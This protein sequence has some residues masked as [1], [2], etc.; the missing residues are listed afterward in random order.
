MS[1]AET[2]TSGSS[3]IS[4]VAS[5]GFLRGLVRI[6]N[7]S[8]EVGTVVIRGIDDAGNVIRTGYA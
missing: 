3:P 5:D 7:H 8:D 2:A 1:Q 4:P 6:V